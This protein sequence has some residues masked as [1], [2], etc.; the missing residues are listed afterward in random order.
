MSRHR[1]GFAVFRLIFDRSP[2]VEQVQALLTRMAIDNLAGHLLFEQ[3]ESSTDGSM[4]LIYIEKSRV[5]FVQRLFEQLLPEARFAK[6]ERSEYDFVDEVFRIKLSD[7]RLA[8]KTDRVE[9]F[10]DTIRSAMKSVLDKY[11]DEAVHLMISISGR[12]RAFE[13]SDAFIGSFRSNF[14]DIMT[15]GNTADL[16]KE[17]AKG[18]RDK[19]AQAGF[20][21][22]VRLGIRAKNLWRRKTIREEVQNA[23]RVLEMTGSRIHFKQTSEKDINLLMLPYGKNTC[24]SPKEMTSFLGWTKGSKQC[25][26]SLATPRDYVATERI[27]GHSTAEDLEGV[28]IGISPEASVF[29]TDLAGGTG[30]GKSNVKKSL[31]VQ[32]ILAG[33]NV[34]SFDPKGD[35]NEEILRYIPRNR[36]N[37][38]VFIDPYSDWPVGM[39]NFNPLKRGA[40]IDH[41]T[42]GILTVFKKTFADAWGKRTEDIMAS[43]LR[44]LALIPDANLLMLPRLLTDADFR[45]D[46]VAKATKA[47]PLGV[48]SFWKD[49]EAMGEIARRNMIA[50]LM[51]RLRSFTLREPLRHV[52]GQTN[53][54]FNMDDLFTKSRIVLV[55]LNKGENSE[56]AHLLGSLF[57]IQLWAAIMARGK[58]PQSQRKLISVYIDE[59]QDY[60]DMPFKLEDALSQARG[61]GVGFTFAHQYRAQ[62][63]KELLESIDANVKNRVIFA[64][65]PND[66]AAYAKLSG[67]LLSAEDFMR[68]K[69]YHVYLQT[70]H[71]DNSVWMSGETWKLPDSKTDPNL[72]KEISKRNYGVPKEEVD[73]FNIGQANIDQDTADM[74]DDIEIGKAKR[75]ENE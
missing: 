6:Y 64:S 18:V 49:Y 57:M 12:Y 3:V 33:R 21:A 54:K 14:I 30:S 29:H 44:V 23:I 61:L 38:V 56:V 55:S 60:L 70:L 63:P 19:F 16:T 59:A 46:V 8:M 27:I 11:E 66:A 48:G 7:P 32:D 15:G 71:N 47:D 22:N 34:I 43:S 5:D 74:L 39:N 2:E 51:S 4:C 41:V 25:P 36:L 58:L 67:G 24:L 31:I 20:Q 52:L 53:P 13:V 75:G 72:V 26:V 50:P 62:F 9:Y 42:D 40:K 28:A 73:Q 1:E 10:V 45:R 35:L 65:S 69:R 37:D 17:E 68:L